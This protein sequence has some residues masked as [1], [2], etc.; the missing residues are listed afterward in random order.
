VLGQQEPGPSVGRLGVHY[1][2]E[3]G[4]RL[5][6]AISQVEQELLEDLRVRIR[7][8]RA[9]L[10]RPPQRLLGFHRADGRALE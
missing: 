10:S 9:G 8:E 2:L 4:Q 6:I 3:H 5:S 1:I 7:L